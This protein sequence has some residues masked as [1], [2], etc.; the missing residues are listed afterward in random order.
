[1]Q[2]SDS[3]PEIANRQGHSL[4]ALLKSI[5]G[6]ARAFRGSREAPMSDS[7]NKREQ[8]EKIWQRKPMD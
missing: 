5:D 6:N 4:N 2:W 8:R 1:M 3:T 7:K